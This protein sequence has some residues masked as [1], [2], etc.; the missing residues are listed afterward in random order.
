MEHF[1][2]DHKDYPNPHNSYKLCNETGHP[3]VNLTESQ[4]GLKQEHD[5]NS[6]NGGKAI[7]EQILPSEE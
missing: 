7:V 3:V 4:W 5:Q 6:P 1:S 2:N